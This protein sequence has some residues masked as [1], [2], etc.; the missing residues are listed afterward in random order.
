MRRGDNNFF[1]QKIEFILINAVRTASIQSIGLSNE[2]C[3]L[4][5]GLETGFS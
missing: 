1:V 4:M 3:G 2:I 5:A